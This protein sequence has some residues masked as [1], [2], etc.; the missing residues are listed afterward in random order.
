MSG[1][2]IDLRPQPGEIEFL[3]VGD[4]VPGEA[5]VRDGIRLI[6]HMPVRTAMRRPLAMRGKDWSGMAAHL[7][8]YYALMQG[9]KGEALI[10]QGFGFELP[11]E[12]RLNHLYTEVDTVKN[13]DITSQDLQ[14]SICRNLLTEEANIVGYDDDRNDNSLNIVF[15]ETIMVVRRSLNNDGLKFLGDCSAHVR[16]YE[17]TPEELAQFKIDNPSFNNPNVIAAVNGVHYN[18]KDV[19]F[20]FPHSPTTPGLTMTQGIMLNGIN[21]QE[22]G[23]FDPIRPILGLELVANRNC[24]FDNI[25]VGTYDIKQRI[26]IDYGVPF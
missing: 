18:Q 8:N 16:T 2:E 12:A 15:N 17:L 6:D 19:E 22:P 20:K 25:D 4:Q 10:A 24:R 21:T 3:R 26:Y 5:V 1:E 11:Q 13:T 23:A 9:P 14:L 7:Q